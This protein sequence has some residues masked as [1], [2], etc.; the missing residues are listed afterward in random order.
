MDLTL[1]ADSSFK[2]GIMQDSIIEIKGKRF[3]V[4]RW[5]R[6]NMYTLEFHDISEEQIK[7]FFRNPEYVRKLYDSNIIK[8]VSL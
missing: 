2:S 4:D 5:N 1:Y 6:G 7:P 8:V 3:R